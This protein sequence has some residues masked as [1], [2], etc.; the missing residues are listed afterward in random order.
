M[1]AVDHRPQVR[2]AEL[3]GV[4]ERGMAT[5]VEVGSALAEIRESRLYRETHRDFDSYCRERWGWSARHVNRQIEAAT[6]VAELGP[7]GPTS[8]RQARELARVEPER[9]AEV[10]REASENGAPTAAR[11]REVAAP[12]LTRDDRPPG[13]PAGGPPATAEAVGITATEIADIFRRDPADY[14]L[15]EISKMSRLALHL[16]QYADDLADRL[17]NASVDDRRWMVQA[18]DEIRWVVAYADEQLQAKST[19]KAVT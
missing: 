17:I 6:V 16:R 19:L 14:L 9:R 2:L 15:T 13:R 4:I 8:E 5:F 3:E 11:I 18:L 1:S 10:W 12:A 7:T